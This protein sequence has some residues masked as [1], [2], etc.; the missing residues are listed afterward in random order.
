MWFFD[1]TYKYKCKTNIYRN[2]DNIDNNVE[3]FN[4]GVS[5]FIFSP[6]CEYLLLQYVL[7]VN[8]NTTVRLIISSV[9]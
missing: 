5:L 7:L 6:F 8:N 9:V 4:I 3:T 2:I 1:V